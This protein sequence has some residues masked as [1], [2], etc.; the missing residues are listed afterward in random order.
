M[1]AGDKIRVIKPIRESWVLK[2]RTGQTGVINKMEDKVVYIQLNNG[3][4]IKTTYDKIEPY[5]KSSR[6]NIQNC[7]NEEL[8]DRYDDVQK[9]IYY[10]SMNTKK[11]QKANE[12]AEKLRLAILERMK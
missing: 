4:I 7:S 10:D 11:W 6:F 8:L 1:Q 9:I 5:T 12:D 3:E 2:A